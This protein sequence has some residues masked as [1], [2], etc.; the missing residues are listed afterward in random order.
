MLIGMALER[1]GQIARWV[2]L[3]E[4]KR[5]SAQLAPKM[6][7]GR[8]ESGVNAASR[9][10]GIE[11]TDVQRAVKVAS[12]SD[13]AKRAAEEHGLADN[14]SALLDADRQSTARSRGLDR[15]GSTFRRAPAGNRYGNLLFI[16]PLEKGQ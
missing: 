16:N 11:R 14:R 5:I 12:L 13:E 15:G 8:P 1:S 4:A 2:E 9:D 7:R 6:D 3:V 10:L